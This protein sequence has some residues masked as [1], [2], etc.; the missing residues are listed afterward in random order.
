MTEPLNWPS[1]V[2]EAKRRRKAEG[3]TQRHHA[4]L[5]GVSAPTMGAF[6][7][8]ATTLTLAR[9]LD[10]LRVVGLVAEETPRSAQDAF[11]AAALAR[12]HQLVETLPASA[13]A[14]HP[15]GNYAADYQILGIGEAPSVMQLAEML[16]RDMPRL[17]GWPVFWWPT[18][19][20]IAPHPLGSLIECWLAPEQD[21]AF[22]DAAHSDFWRVDVEG[23]AVLLR[24]YQEDSADQVRPGT[25]FD[26]TLPI[27]RCGEL[28]KHAERLAEKLD[29]DAGSMAIRL[30]VAYRGLVGR[31]LASWAAAARTLPLLD[32]H[33][34]RVGEVLVDVEASL[35]EVGRDL[36]G[37]LH[38]LLAPLYESFDFYRLDRALVDQEVALLLQRRSAD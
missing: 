28:L 17:T 3:L 31:R 7:R 14:R 34:C 37:V 2:A 13:P 6:D 10:I 20:S 8:G 5:A 16:R 29:R 22:D 18:K 9:A 1:L 24:G 35:E 12:W 4:A 32:G 30:R 38:R 27:W 15:H 36:P 21:R 25:I 11:V 19:E 33:I 26:L 23:R